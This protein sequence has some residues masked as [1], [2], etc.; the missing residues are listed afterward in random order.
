MHFVGLG[1]RQDVVEA[2][3]LY[4]IAAT[5]LGDPVSARH[6]ASMHVHGTGCMK[7]WE[8][9]SGLFTWSAQRASL[10]AVQRLQRIA[11]EGKTVVE[12]R[13]LH[14]AAK[15]GDADAMRMMAHVLCGADGGEAMRVLGVSTRTADTA[16]AARRLFHDAAELGSP[17]AACDFAH[18]NFMGWGGAVD[19]F[20]FE[21]ALLSMSDQDRL[22]SVVLSSMPTVAAF[23]A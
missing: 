20:E 9:A 12:L 18:M 16:S 23:A 8:T 3:R 2:Y 7:C 5:Q 17:D 11:E 19:K 22:V 14:A 15:N 4:R 21:W 10:L 13:R 6:M 1:G